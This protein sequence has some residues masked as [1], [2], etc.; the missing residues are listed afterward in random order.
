MARPSI[1]ICVCSRPSRSRSLYARA[2][3]PESVGSEPQHSLNAHRVR[4][5]FITL[6][7]KWYPSGTPLAPFDTMSI[8]NFGSSILMSRSRS[9]A[10]GGIAGT[11][12]RIGLAA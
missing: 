5:S 9:A 2:L 8:T 7:Y 4:S 6:K 12:T 10:A 3:I 1:T 11:A